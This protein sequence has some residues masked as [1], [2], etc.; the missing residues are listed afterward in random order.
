MYAP[1]YMYAPQDKTLVSQDK[2]LNWQE[3]RQEVVAYF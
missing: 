3:T 1:L 2:T